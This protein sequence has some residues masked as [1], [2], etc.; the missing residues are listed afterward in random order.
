VLVSWAEVDV[1]HYRTPPASFPLPISNQFSPDII[2]ALPSS[3][4]VIVSAIHHH[5]RRLFFDEASACPR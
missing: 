1:L 3:P 2:A 4:F 5:N